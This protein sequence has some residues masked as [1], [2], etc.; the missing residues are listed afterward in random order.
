MAGLDT[1]APA[2]AQY[3][4]TY[5]SDEAD[6]RFTVL[7]SAGTLRIRRTMPE[8]N[9]VLR[10]AYRDGFSSPAGNVV[11]TRGTNGRVNG[12]LLTLPRVRN[13]RFVRQP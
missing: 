8:A 5:Y 2:R 6:A 11:F 10:P 9:A 7:D 3:A 13:L 1:S 4:G 12:F